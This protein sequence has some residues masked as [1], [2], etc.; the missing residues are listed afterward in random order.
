MLTN[1]AVQAAF[2]LAQS[3]MANKLT[4]VAVDPSPLRQLVEHTTGLYVNQDS[5]GQYAMSFNEGSEA[6]TDSVGAGIIVKSHDIIIDE[7]VPELAKAVMNHISY[8]KNVVA[9]AVEH[10]VEKVDEALKIVPRDETMS[11]SIE[12]W[13]PPQPLVHPSFE[14]L[15]SKFGSI[16]INPT[17]RL[18]FVMPAVDPEVLPERAK[19]GNS[20][21]DISISVWLAARGEKFLEN[22]YYNVFGSEYADRIQGFIGQRASWSGNVTTKLDE[23]VAIFLLSNG[24]IDN[25]PD[26]VPVTLSNFN[27]EM[28]TLNNLAGALLHHELKILEANMTTKPVLIRFI[29]QGERQIVVNKEIYDQFLEQGGDAD[30]VLGSLLSKDKPYL[31]DHFLSK[32]TELAALWNKHVAIASASSEKFMFA[33]TKSA[34]RSVFGAMIA[35][36]KD[37][38]DIPRQLIFKKFDD[39][40]AR[41]TERDLTEPYHVALR[42]LCRARYYRTDAEKLLGRIDTIVKENPKLD[43]REASTIAEIE[44]VSDWCFDQMR[45]A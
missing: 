9:P 8:A 42:L 18:P 19:T 20:D 35:E 45:L 26:G 6:T 38:L 44:Y 22:V 39:E 21:L 2:P 40:L 12:V 41:I 15:L 17:Y 14:A 32:K 16:E 37:D 28:R 36:D 30:A 34:M 13:N 29:D 27:L 10:F 23:L 11:Y 31:L 1:E 7:V 24:F 3:L 4:L 33:K 5:N 43:V 25:P